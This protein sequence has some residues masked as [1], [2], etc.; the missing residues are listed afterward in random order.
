MLIRILELGVVLH[1]G[2]C[3]LVL[4]GLQQTLDFS[5]H[6][7]KINLTISLAILLHEFKN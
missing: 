7:L 5:L 4:Q 1:G 6:T 2:Y 3:L